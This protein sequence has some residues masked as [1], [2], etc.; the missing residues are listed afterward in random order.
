M[1]DGARAVDVLAVG[2]HR[3]AGPVDFL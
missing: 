3:R 1:Q 2:V